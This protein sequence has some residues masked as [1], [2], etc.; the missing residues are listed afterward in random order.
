M[1]NT[2]A[3]RCLDLIAQSIAAIR[4]DVP[5][6]TAL[7]EKMA[8]PLLAGGNLF[9]PKIGVYWPSEFGSRAGGLM[10]LKPSDYVAE[11]AN[12]V[13]Y[14]TLPDPRRANLKTDARFR[15]LLDSK[16]Q[17]FVIGREQDLGDAA[18]ISR[19]AGFTGGA[20]PESPDAG[21]YVDKAHGPVAPLRPFE[22][23]V[24]GWA[25]AGEMV[26]AMT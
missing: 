1:S 24:R 15:R 2:P 26:A 3:L 20:P 13:A 17:I 9:T 18:P 16:A 11:S 10:G 5:R 14:T 4:A 19:I 23:L 25:T 12:D 6:L 22:Q 7:G 8:A 21:L